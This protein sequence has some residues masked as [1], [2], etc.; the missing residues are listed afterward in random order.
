MSR[1]VHFL[2]RLAIFLILIFTGL[3]TVMISIARLQAPHRLLASFKLGCQGKPSPCW[4][5]IVP[6]LTNIEEARRIL[7]KAGYQIGTINDTSGYDYFYSGQLVPGCIKIGYSPD[8]H[9]LNYLRLYCI[10]TVS[11][12]DVIADLGSPKNIIYIPSPH[13]DTEFLT[14][15][16]DS[17]LS[18]LTL[19]TGTGWGS[20]L[21]PLVSFEIFEAHPSQPATVP[22]SWHGFIELAQ[23]C[24]MEPD[25]PRCQ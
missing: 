6:G 21:D 22:S 17:S 19:S 5:G 23:Y 15:A 1:S 2:S 3:M 4:D 11:V 13:G 12:G 8:T 9:T 24:Q 18:G 10:Q 20:P 25:F 14:Y 16:S 7:Q